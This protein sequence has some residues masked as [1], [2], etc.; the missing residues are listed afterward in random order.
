MGIT[1]L[2]CL[3]CSNN[4][5]LHIYEYSNICFDLLYA[6]SL[7]KVFRL[8]RRGGGYL[9]VGYFV[10]LYVSNPHHRKSQPYYP[11]NITSN[12]N[13][14][15]Q[16]TRGIL[17]HQTPSLR[18]NKDCYPYRG[19]LLGASLHHPFCTTCLCHSIGL[20]GVAPGIQCAERKGGVGKDGVGAKI[21]FV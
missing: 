9:V 19:Q 7:L 12:Y 21:R 8:Q 3:F 17:V 16:M 1:F 5:Q 13:K 15:K 4:T 20:R 10:N 2:H 11:T 6:F 14:T 18:N